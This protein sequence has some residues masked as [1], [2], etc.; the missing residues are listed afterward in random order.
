VVTQRAGNGQTTCLQPANVLAAAAINR[1][2]PGVAGSPLLRLSKQV[3]LGNKSLLRGISKGGAPIDQ[4]GDLQLCAAAVGIALW[5]KMSAMRD[6]DLGIRGKF[7]AWVER[8]GDVS[9]VLACIRSRW[10]DHSANATQ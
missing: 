5:P 3:K 7:F 9:L 10:A 8:N 6:T 4:S 2:R 1:T